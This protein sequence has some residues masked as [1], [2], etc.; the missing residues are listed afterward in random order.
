MLSLTPVPGSLRE[1][2][3]NWMVEVK[4]S[5]HALLVSRL[6]LIIDLEVLACL[7]FLFMV[8]NS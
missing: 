8:M 5:K 1:G 7:L 2:L 4:V 3:L 6:M